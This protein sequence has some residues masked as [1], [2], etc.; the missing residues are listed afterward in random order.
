MPKQ[1]IRNFQNRKYQVYC[2]LSVSGPVFR[3]NSGLVRV[4]GLWN[5]K[6]GVRLAYPSGSVK[7][8]NRRHRTL[9]LKPEASVFGLVNR[10]R[11]FQFFGT[12]NTGQLG[13]FPFLSYPHPPLRSSLIIFFSNPQPLKKLIFHCFF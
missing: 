5:Q 13:T 11:K 6:T 10:N 4:T 8:E 12:G 1:I 2:L 9:L 3:L 7:I